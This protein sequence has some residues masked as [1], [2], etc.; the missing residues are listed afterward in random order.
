[1]PLRP[2]RLANRLPFVTSPARRLR[3]VATDRGWLAPAVPGSDLQIAA[4]M[5]EPGK[6]ADAVRDIQALCDWP[7]QASPNLRRIDVP[8]ASELAAVRAF[9]PAR[10]LLS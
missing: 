2:G 3:G 6:E 10:V 9:D 8:S 1:M 4:V 7:I 5:A